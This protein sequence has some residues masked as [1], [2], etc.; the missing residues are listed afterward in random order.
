[1]TFHIWNISLSDAQDFKRYERKV[2]HEQV[3][4]NTKDEAE[5]DTHAAI[6]NQPRF[7]GTCLPSLL[8]QI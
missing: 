7:L 3:S 5:Q 1:M 2:T 6:L 4:D 8:G